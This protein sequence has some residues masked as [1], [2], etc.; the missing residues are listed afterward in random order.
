MMQKRTAPE[1][2]HWNDQ[3]KSLPVM[4]EPIIPRSLSPRSTLIQA[5]RTALM[6]SLET[7]DWRL[8]SWLLRYPF[9]RADD[10]VVGMAR[11]ISRATV[12]RHLHALEQH[13][14]IASVL[15]KTPAEGKRLYHLSNLGL[16][17]LAAQLGTSART[18]ARDWQA[19]EAGLLRLVP[20]LPILLSLQ[21]LVNGLVTH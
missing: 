6:A 2:Q 18:L 13:A 16:H 15:P 10:L 21:S 5:E 20:R 12:Y 3:Q 9:Q 17:L 7:L 19:D 1:D 14:L 4:P 8:L 11:W